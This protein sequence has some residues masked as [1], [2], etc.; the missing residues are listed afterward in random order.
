MPELRAGWWREEITPR[1]GTPMAGYI[2]RRGTSTGILDSLYA[3]VLVLEQGKIR[4]AIFLCDVLLIS[5]H[6][7]ARLR[8]RLGQLLGIPASRIIVAATHTHSGP[9]LDTAPFRFS[10]ASTR[11][12]QEQSCIEVALQRAGVRATA[13]LLPVQ[14][15]FARVSIAG[16][17]SDR[18]HPGRRTKQNVFL[19]RFR[20][21]RDTALLGVYGCHPT[22]LGFENTQFSGDLHGEISRRLEKKVSIALLANGA[23]ANI[24]TRFSRASQNPWELRRLARLACCQLARA[25][26][27]SIRHP[28][29]AVRE[30]QFVLQRRDLRHQ[31]PP[32]PAKPGRLGVVA[33]EAEQVRELLARSPSFAKRS[34]P[35]RASRLALNH[36]S[37]AALPFELYADTGDFL[38]RKARTI[39]I[40]YANGYWGYVPSAAARENEYEAVSSLFDS[41]ADAR[42]RRALLH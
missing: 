29:L 20:T 25:R 16:V 32:L 28:R 15:D 3:R 38:W 8:Q 9:L 39:C 6:W 5:N 41:R 12:R 19:F 37:L 31:L 24:S 23:A 42:L 2:A 30:I 34:S 22:V 33:R 10:R 27:R 26:F 1:P 36:L 40:C 14:L 7:A 21:P 17:A 18:N 13:R 11:S 4:V 35:I